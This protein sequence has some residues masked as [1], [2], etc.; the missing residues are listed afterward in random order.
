MNPSE[1]ITPSENIIP[2][3]EY[4][5]GDVFKFGERFWKVYSVP[6]DGTV[7]AATLH[8]TPF[9]RKAFRVEEK[10]CTNAN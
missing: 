5:C 3:G 7:W 1:N 10:V 9:L 4:R 8:M 6:H 2:S